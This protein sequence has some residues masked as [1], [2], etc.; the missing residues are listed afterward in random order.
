VETTAAAANRY[1]TVL[2]KLP[3]IAAAKAPIDTAAINRENASVG[4]PASDGPVGIVIDGVGGGGT[5]HDKFAKT[6]P[7]WMLV[8]AVVYVFV[9]VV[10]VEF[11]TTSCTAVCICV[12]TMVDVTV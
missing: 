10:V 9:V 12:I 6:P 2:D 7:G 8:T 4:Y 1:T 5:E 11:I 3:T